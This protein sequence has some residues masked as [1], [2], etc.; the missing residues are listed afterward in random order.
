MTRSTPAGRTP[1]QFLIPPEYDFSYQQMWQAYHGD[2]DAWR[3]ATEAH[4]DAL[5]AYAV[6]RSPYYGRTIRRGAPFEDIPLLSKG[7]LRDHADEVMARDVPAWRRRTVQTS[8]S[9]GEPVTVHR[10]IHQTLVEATAS[11]RFFRAL[12]GVPF[13]ATIIAVT[14]TS[15][16]GERFSRW[17]RPRARMAAALG[18]HASS[19]PWM[20]TFPSLRARTPPEMQRHLDL[21]GRLRKYFFIGQASTLDRI[22]QEIEAGRVRL[23]RPPVAIASTSDMLTSQAKE[24]MERVFGAWV[25]T[26]YGSIEVPFLA[27]SL[28]NETDR[29]IFNP[30]LAYVEVVDDQGRPVAPRETGRVVVTDLNNRVMPLIRYVMGDLAVASKEG[31]VGG[32]RLIEGLIGRESELLRFPSG[33][34]LNGSNLD[35]LLFHKDGFARWV[36]A[37]QCRQTGPNEVEL[38]V[39]WAERSDEV[40]TRIGDVLRAAADPDTAVRVRSVDELERHPSG[41]TWIVR[42]LERVD[43][44]ARSG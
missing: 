29:Y 15:I 40:A 2:T 24:R 43:A 3:R 34:V 41:K 38:R 19:D 13:D 8:G 9:T 14:S 20:L 4:R 44:S 23:R 1:L 10:D 22:A 35:K 16:S 36:R 30:L 32:F 11:D 25:H 27:G 5:V 39:V 17:G 18:A 28:P 26:R 12:H 33:R 21:W 31:F 6:Q 37:F 7:A 42:G